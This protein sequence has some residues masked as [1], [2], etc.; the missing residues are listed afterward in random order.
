MRI[1]VIHN[2]SA[3]DEGHPAADILAELRALGHDVS[4]ASTRRGWQA[5]VRDPGDLVI[6]AGGDGTVAKVARML[7]GGAIP[8]AILPLGTAN[9][10][11]RT[12]GQRGSWRVQLGALPDWPVRMMDVGVSRGAWGEHIFIE[13][14]G[15]GLFADAMASDNMRGDDLPTGRA[16]TLDR[17]IV[18]VHDQLRRTVARRYSIEADDDAWDVEAILVAI[19]NARSIGPQLEF[20]AGATPFD[21]LLDLVVAGE[22]DRPALDRYLAARTAGRRYELRLH[23]LTARRIRV[24]SHE[25]GSVH[26]DDAR[27]V[28]VRGCDAAFEIRPACLPV[29]VPPT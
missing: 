10:V 20:A 7:I 29:L 19:M 28:G 4:Y 21:G 24:V 27:W 17:D 8:L 2:I 16:T 22:F 1:T 25:H 23:T 3:G 18:H 15:L 9:N 26:C 14:A 11:A 6:A 13:G 5:V 12:L